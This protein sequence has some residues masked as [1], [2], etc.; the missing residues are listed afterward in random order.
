MRI[1]VWYNSCVRK[2]AKII[3]ISMIA[4]VFA[5]A[6]VAVSFV[7]AIFAN[8]DKCAKGQYKRLDLLN[9]TYVSGEYEPV[10]EQDFCDFDLQSAIDGGAKLIDLQFLATHNSYKKEK[11]STEKLFSKFSKELDG[12]NYYFEN[13]TDQLNVGIRSFE[14]DIFCRRQK[15]GVSFH[16]FHIGGLDMSSNAFDFSA[17]LEEINLWSK[18]NPNHLPLTIIIELKNRGGMYPYVPI[19]GKDLDD[20]DNLLKRKITNLYTPSQAFEGYENLNEMRAV[21]DSPS[22][23]ETMGKVLFIL[24]RGDLTDDYINLDKEYKSQAMFPS[25]Y[26]WWDETIGK[27]QFVII[28]NHGYFEHSTEENGGRKHGYLFRIMIDDESGGIPDQET[29]NQALL[30]GATIC[31][32]NHPPLLNA[33][34][35]YSSISFVPNGK[36]VRLAPKV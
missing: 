25:G 29:I 26:F 22:L 3:L 6:V 24:H 35:D 10:Q 28:N 8:V 32:T 19:E 21:E 20:F 36:T 18:A 17:C 15:S 9:K 13:I 2:G 30:T 16:S 11:S 31:S 23:A 27:H 7:V 12:G 4:L 1:I 14:F 5:V 34:H 33:R